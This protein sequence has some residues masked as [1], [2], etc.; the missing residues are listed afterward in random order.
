M[1]LSLNIVSVKG[2]TNCKGRV[3]GKPCVIIISRL[4]SHDAR[5]CVCACVRACAYACAKGESEG[6]QLYA[7]VSCQHAG[8]ADSGQY[9]PTSGKLKFLA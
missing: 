2:V 5:L 1:S 7:G 8:S 6:K 4:R 9:C 3:T